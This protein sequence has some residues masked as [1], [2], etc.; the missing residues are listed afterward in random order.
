M[1]GAL[2]SVSREVHTDAHSVAFAEGWEKISRAEMRRITCCNKNS[3]IEGKVKN[4]QP[5]QVIQSLSLT[6][7]QKQ[8]AVQPVCDQ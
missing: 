6:A 4:Q 5:I 8:T 7:F 1:C 3:L 2:T